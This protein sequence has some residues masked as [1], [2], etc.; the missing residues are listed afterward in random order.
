MYRYN[1]GVIFCTGYVSKNLKEIDKRIKIWTYE[2]IV[3]LL[4][5]HLGSEWVK[6]LDLI[7]K[8]KKE[9]HN[10]RL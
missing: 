9:E 5:A 2:E 10:I 6:D 8:T 4:N 7:I 1:R 3:I